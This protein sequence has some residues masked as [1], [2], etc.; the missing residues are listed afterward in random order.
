MLA[1]DA[2]TCV[3]RLTNDYQFGRQWSTVTRMTTYDALAETAAE[4]LDPVFPDLDEATFADLVDE[5]LGQ[6]AR[7]LGEH[8]SA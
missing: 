4:I 2:G 6:V 5:V 7:V 1:R 8:T 3:R